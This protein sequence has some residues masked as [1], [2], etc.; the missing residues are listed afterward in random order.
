MIRGVFLLV[1]VAAVAAHFGL[2]SVSHAVSCGW[3]AYR[4]FADAHHHH[5]GWAGYQLWRSGRAC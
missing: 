4:L 2:F 3:H 5:Y 1:V